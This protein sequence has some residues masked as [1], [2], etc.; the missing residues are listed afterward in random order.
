MKKQIIYGAK[1]G[2]LG[3]II[4]VL[5]TIN[6][7]DF[8]FETDTINIRGEILKE[9]CNV[10]IKKDNISHIDSLKKYGN[11]E[12][13][14]N[15]TIVHQSVAFLIGFELYNDEIDLIPKLNLTKE[16]LEYGKNIIDNFKKPC[17]G[18]CPL[19]ARNESP[20]LDWSKIINKLKEKYTILYL[21]KNKNSQY[22]KSDYID[23]S[24]SNIYSIR[25]IASILKN[26]Y[27]YLGVDTGLTHLSVSVRSKTY[28]IHESINSI[29]FINYAYT[30]RMWRHESCKS[31]YY[32]P[33]QQELLIKELMHD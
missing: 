14:N 32:D 17:L 10:I 12:L 21:S 26:C 23:F 8:T 9:N 19:D 2:S 30:P 13:F 3:D 31:F 11:L 25:K 7:S 4:T 1:D 20:N 28:V 16:E 5:P 33:S 22:L 15:Q 18:F 6:S 29:K 27:R 24:D